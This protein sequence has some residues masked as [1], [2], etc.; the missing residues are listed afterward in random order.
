MANNRQSR[1]RSH[2]T[3]PRRRAARL[4]LEVLEE[5]R[6]LATDSWTSA[7]SGSWNNASNWSTGSVPQAGDAVVIDVAGANPTVTFT[8]G[9]SGPYQSVTV[10]DTL[11]VSYGELSTDSAQINGSLLL[12]NG[13]V[14]DLAAS[15]GSI[16]L[17]GTTTWTQGDF[18]GSGNVVNTGTI[19]IPG[20]A[21]H[22]VA[23]PTLVNEGQINLGG[24]L[25]GALT[26]N[27]G[28]T[29]DF[30]GSGIIAGAFTNQ[31]TIANSAAGTATIS[32]QGAFSNQGGTFDVTAGTLV[33]DGYGGTSTGATF[34]VSPGAQVDL[35]GNETWGG[36]ITGSG[37][38]SVVINIDTFDSINANGASFNFPTGMLNWENGTIY[39][40]FTNL[41][42][43]TIT[44]QSSNSVDV[45]NTLNNT[46]TIEINGQLNI[47]NLNNQ[48]GGTI[49]LVGASTIS[50]TNFTNQGTLDTTEA[51]T[52]TIN[53]TAFNNQAAP[54]NVPAGTLVIDNY[55]GTS[56]G[57]TF[58]VATGAQVD[59]DDGDATW[60]GTITG[61]GGGSVV[62]DIG[63]VNADG[64]SFNFPAGMLNWVNGTIF[65]T[66]TNFGDLT[67]TSQSSNSLDVGNTLNN[68]GTIEIN[69]QLNLGDIYTGPA[70]AFLNNQ[71]GGT[72]TL[73]GNAVISGGNSSTFNNQ[74]TLDK[75]GAGSAA[76][77]VGDFNN[78]DAPINVSAGSLV[79]ESGGT[80]TGGVFTVAAGSELDIPGQSSWT[81]DYTGS[82]GGLVVFEPG[83][84][85]DLNLNGATLNFPAGML[86]WTT[87]TLEGDFTNLGSMTMSGTA[88]IYLDGT[89][90]NEGSIDDLSVASINLQGSAYG[91]G[92]IVNTA[93][94]TLTLGGTSLTIT[95]NASSTIDNE[96]TI[97]IGQ[98]LYVVDSVTTA[99]TGT[100]TLG[101]NSTVGIESTDSSGV[102]ATGTYNVGAG[103]L[104]QFLNLGSITEN[105][106]TIT[107]DGAG[108]SIPQLASLATNAGTLS[109]AD[110]ASLTVDG[111]LEN[112]GTV[113]LA[114]GGVL[115]VP[116]TFT[117]TAAGTLAAQVGTYNGAPSVGLLDV[118]GAAQIGGN[119]TISTVAG[120]GQV[121]NQALPVLDYASETGSFA[122]VN[123]LSIGPI[124]VYQL[125]VN[126]I[127][128]TLTSVAPTSDLATT[129]VIGPTGTLAIGAPLTVDYTV[130]NEGANPALG[131][132]T[133][134]VYLSPNGGLTSSSI[135][136]GRTVYT[137][138]LAA[139]AS[140]NGS[141]TTVVPV[142]VGNYQVVV[143]TDSGETT[144]DINR[145]NNQAASANSFTVTVPSLDIGGSTS[146]TLTAGQ[147]LLYEV[148]VPAGSSVGLTLNVPAGSAA[149]LARA[150]D[151]PSD[152]TFDE[153]DFS[154]TDNQES[155]TVG[156]GQGGPVYVMIEPQSTTSAGT[157]FTLSAQALSFAAT[158]ISP[159]QA[160]EGDTFSVVI[161]G[162]QFTPNTTVSLV[163]QNGVVTP[164]QVSYQNSSEILAT[165]GA[166]YNI[167]GY[168]V[169]VS[170][171]G[172]TSTL[173]NVFQVNGSV[174]NFTDPDSNNNAIVLTLNTPSV[175]RAGTLETLTIDYT[176]TADYPI[177]APLLDLSSSSAAFA[178]V[179]SSNYVEH[180]LML[181]AIDQSGPAGILPP[182]YSGQ[183]KVSARP[184]SNAIH[185]EDFF[186][187]SLVNDYQLVEAPVEP[188]GYHLLQ[189]YGPVPFDWPTVLAPAQPS[190]MSSAGW[191][192]VLAN[193]EA[194]V[195]T[196]FPQLQA[197]LDQDATYLSSLGEHVS[198][199]EDLIGFELDRAEGFGTITSASTL[200]SLGYGQFSNADLKATVDGSGDVT[201]SQDGQPLFFG[202]QPD[203][204]YLS[205]DGVSSTLSLV[206]GA[207]QLQEPDGTVIAFNTDGTFH[208]QTNPDGTSLVAA[209]SGGE[210]STLTDN[211]GQVT[212]FTWNAQGT[213]AQVVA[214]DGET[215][216]FGYDPTGTFLTSMTDASGTTQYQYGQ[217][218]GSLEELTSVIDPTGVAT[219]YSYD[220]EGRLIGTNVAGQQPLTISYPTNSPGEVD[221]TDATGATTRYLYDASGS[222]VATIDPSGQMARATLD[223]NSNITAFTYPDGSVDTAT[224]DSS[225]DLLSLIDPLGDRSSFTYDP[226]FHQLTSYTDANGYTTTYT[227][228]AQGETTGTTYADGTTD[229]T[230]YNSQGQVTST[231]GRD[232]LTTTLAY[233]PTS[234]DV[235]SASFGDG[236]QSTYT[237]DAHHNILT[238]TNAQG[239]TTFTY[240]AAN[241]LTSVAYPN[242]LSLSYNYDAA[243]RQ[244]SITDQ[245]GY[246]EKLV[247]DSAG[248]LSEVTDGS[249]NVLVA[250]TYDAAGRVIDQVNANGTSTTT[251]YNANGQISEIDNLGS[252]G[253]VLSKFAYTYD[254]NG[255][256]L[257]MTTLQGVTTYQYDAAG[258][259][260]S[261]ALP[262]GET[263][264]YKYD[265]DG[266]I[267][268]VTDSGTTT[269]S[270]VNNVDELTSSGPTTYNYNA[271]GYLISMTNSTGTTSYSY[272]ASG[273]LISVTSPTA[274]TYQYL[275]DALGN[276][277]ATIH[278]GV[279]TD[280]LFDPTGS[281]GDSL[282]GQ[283]SGT[284]TLDHYVYGLGLAAQVGASGA[285]N[286][287][288]FD[289]QGNTS[290]L[291][292]PNGAVLNQYS[293][294]P[295]GALASSSGSAANLFTFGGQLGV[296]SDGNGLAWMRNREYDPSSAR[297]TQ[298]DPT[299]LAGGLNAYE[300]AGDAPTV[301]ADPTGL[302]TPGTSPNND[303]SVQVFITQLNN[304]IRAR[305]RGDSS[306]VN[307][308][309]EAIAQNAQAAKDAI[310]NVANGL[311][312]G[313]VTLTTGGLKGLGKN[314]GKWVAQNVVNTY[315]HV[316]YNAPSVLSLMEARFAAN[317]KGAPDDPNSIAGPAGYGTPGF[318]SSGQVLPY[319][320]Y[321]TN[322]PT[323]TAAAD[324]VTIT[325]TLSPNLDW[326]TFQLGTIQLGA[327]T[328][329][330][331]AG[332][333]SYQTQIDATAT[334]GVIVDV[335]AALDL[336]T[337]VVTWTLT[338]LDPTTL[339]IPSNPS[340][341]L[342]PPDDATGRGEGY[343]LYT[344]Q[345]KAGLATGTTI[346]ASAS[347]V[348]DVN[349]AIAT[350]TITNTIDA[351]PPTTVVNPLP[352]NSP[353]VFTLSWTGSEN[354]AGPGIASYDV[355]TSIDGGPLTPIDIG[356]TATSLTIQGQAGHSYAFAVVATDNAGL[357][358]A[359]P[360]SAQVSTTCVPPTMTVTLGSTSPLPV[361][362]TLTLA[363]SIADN[364]PGPYQA[365]VNYGDGTGTSPVTI[366]A[367]GTFSLSHLYTT[368]GPYQ[369]SVMASDGYGGQT[370]STATLTVGSA[371][372]VTTNPTS[373]TVNAG[374]TVT[375]TA[376]ASGNPTPTTVQW[377][378]STD[379]GN[380][381]NPIT[382]ATSTTL[383]FA[384]TAAQNGTE[385]EA[386]FGN[387][388]GTVT[389]TA[390]TLTVDF[391][392]TVTTQPASQTVNAGLTATFTAS[393]SG[394]PT[395]TTVQWQVSTD[396]GNTFNPITGATSTTLSFATTAAQNG[397][398]YEAVFTNSV[399]SA[400]TTPPAI[401]TVDYAPAVTN[402]PASQTVNAGL[403]ATF[404][405]SASGNPA[406]T[407]QWQVSTDG[408][409]TFS[410]IPGATSTTLS[411]ATA[412]AQNGNE[413]Q[414]VFT[415]SVG[416]ATTT[417]P[418]IL[419]VDYAPTVTSSPTSLTVNAG[420][421]ATFMASASDGYPTPTTV[422]WQVS[423]DGGQTFS[424]IAGATS[425][426][427]TLTN[428]TAAQNGSQYEAVFSNATGL[429]SV[430]L[431]ATLTVDYAPMVTNNPTNMTVN[432]GQT[433]TFTA[434]ASDG[435]PTPTTVQWQVSTNGGQKFS[436]IAGATSTTLTLTNTTAAQNGNEY[437]AVFSNAAGLSAT[438]S[439]ATLTVK[440]IAATTTTLTASPSS[441][442]FGQ[443]V[444]FTA[445][446]KAMPP[447]TG[448]PTGSVTF[449]DGSTT[450]GTAVLSTSGKATLMSK[451]LPF[452]SDSI[453]AVY[454]G[455]SKFAASTSPVVTQSISQATTTTTVV[456]SANPSSFGQSV[457]FTATVR[458]VAPGSGVPTGPVK[459][460]LDS[461]TTPLGTIT[462]SSSG[463]ARFTTSGLALGPHTITASYTGDSNFTA[464]ATTAPLTQTVNQAATKTTV[465][466][467]TNPSHFGQPVTFTATVKPAAGS[468]VP[469]GSV[470]FYLDG[471]TMPLTAQ[472][473][474]S[475][476]AK[477]SIE[478]LSVGP[479]TITASYSGDSNFTASATTAP[480]TQTVNQAATKTTVAS[481]VNPSSFGQLVTFTATVSAASPG[482]GVPTGSVNFYLD[483]STTPLDTA[484]LTAGS[485]SFTTS[486]LAVGSHTITASYNGDSNFMATL[487]TAP[488]P[489]V[490]QKVNQA[491]TKTTV[492][493]PSSAV[494]GQLVTFTAT[495]TPLAPGNGVP[496]GNVTFYINNTQETPVL[497]AVNSGADEATFMYTFST[498]GNYTIKAVY[499]GDT[500][501]K[502]SSYSFSLKV[503]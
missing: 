254:A 147:N 46:G 216:T 395:P 349:A 397:T 71:A 358:P 111:N 482:S 401:L 459:F 319:Q 327:L 290:V 258:R 469:T 40:T 492:S 271:D 328:I 110:G 375:F 124:Q 435:K 4:G 269:T 315:Y 44:S 113:V 422:Q 497:L 184:D 20:A 151:L 483:G 332:L 213:I 466:S 296:I 11:E 182:G 106:A 438:T 470:N 1:R 204:S 409:S 35:D 195:G 394:N 183:I 279:R 479:H 25:S 127:Q 45:G 167:G 83:Y 406:P 402:N 225:G 501:F 189:G 447:A 314:A 370:T 185:S 317:R 251:S 48:A 379:G 331:P 354:P 171:A 350:P 275:Y 77:N 472:L 342:L 150:G 159:D 74:G 308:T 107:L 310:A 146:G 339:D 387:G 27:A 415:N 372:S 92:S 3:R 320:V 445:T 243:G 68:T 223:A 36:T 451:Q 280:E 385:Y 64:A 353:P 30:Q 87:Y 237:Y 278:N 500:N 233:A 341:G 9:A 475:G 141:L 8:S 43:L 437:Q 134:S 338:G 139:G 311:Y 412:A 54:I 57:A 268:S 69:G 37:G 287:Y 98:G 256:P 336:N 306:Q 452:G 148:D 63:Q 197:A 22:Q 351:S 247:Y 390:A 285:V 164:T 367:D 345:P 363:G 75:I 419:T 302:K 5:R 241:K 434:S 155:V 112:T 488:L 199:F 29:I 212:T 384:T 153:Y 190:G 344:V 449:T 416:T 266:N 487:T 386:V 388:V 49:T 187:V 424:L 276:P 118:T 398:E 31:G 425:T 176:N 228:N 93:G 431:P 414:A 21:L 198:S 464:S 440:A 399:G 117:Q 244:T 65:G 56:T 97:E 326:S 264:S 90:T 503:K 170:D 136:L 357:S 89:L 361:G 180:D 175:V 484:P 263:L 173:P 24:T 206:N 291:T 374:Q 96:G 125:N 491:A 355:Y 207:Y 407:V 165:F 115:N 191:N 430:T 400:T 174:Y 152:S 284:T 454:S 103:V 218:A 307:S 380:T 116:G 188:I 219:N 274:G 194:N 234:N 42:D 313:A 149:I 348:F 423:T 18:W 373:Q 316:L 114:P 91:P 72:I 53:C 236:T 486:T 383:S 6:L 330:V 494:H 157:N 105:D 23:G 15:G 67:I 229:A 130:E 405:A 78:L 300:Y 169:V 179:G 33:I 55:D 289:A 347:I 140:Y 334:L 238:A 166:I 485:A 273:N 364:V 217:V 421:T 455:D 210:L 458:A 281:F 393:A 389:T 359:G 456:S 270:T 460:Y 160:T 272:D 305:I 301:N 177:P 41:G 226:N 299:G 201:I 443:A 240:N 209:Y 224:Y 138:N 362:S 473:Y 86:E 123:G 17:A 378:V 38:G 214:P 478:T 444:T 304:N 133:D 26:N 39:G 410:I 441:S 420:Q 391:A 58:N 294:L 461:S 235:T 250:Y 417:S 432:A 156:G 324:V 335:S 70:G 340:L 132:W 203:G 333:S 145:A 232:G 215:T 14:I 82:G 28:A 457:T 60:S 200:G 446:V 253:T 498:A 79:D 227:V 408:G 32:N 371:L 368:A 442:V 12:D 413:Y 450:L 261:A 66:F 2:E 84:L 255:N 356:T 242:G 88:N 202:L 95:G 186:S 318:V 303:G 433:A 211:L 121:G 162:S 403:T 7:L 288:G 192:Q 463:N 131:P 277:I 366:A 286:A 499:A 101:A 144:T 428:T 47:D 181:L 282:V 467:S 102:I 260:I 352:A 62:I 325:E 262:G 13:G 436:N 230:T 283:F 163:G 396:G 100:I 104:L 453:T 337:G 16:N 480:L 346:N 249:E 245:S 61:S 297:F 143:L 193:L 465:A 495:V 231:T 246:T 259:L 120:G 404:S 477:I 108:A 257:T 172:K 322:D 490:T 208:S 439:A 343:V 427:L 360:V 267:I 369:I 161:S 129:S 128:T 252:G 392:P 220:S 50:G 381:F 496:T 73:E 295:Y 34:T 411:F 293:Y 59:L 365:T 265:A 298:S 426:T 448:T 142:V 471:S 76:I 323:A 312:S 292:G 52:A 119:L 476:Q 205:Q 429:L 221:V 19:N 418:A 85:S 309:G 239:T 462:L 377:Q 502:T 81:G 196:T 222:I 122:S 137:G 329:T 154:T 94:A 80:S 99:N 10:K 135:L 126:S 248:R 468:G 474:G 376:S 493:P 109:V 178:V 489:T 158:A 382:G 481:S 51:G 321:F 168:Q